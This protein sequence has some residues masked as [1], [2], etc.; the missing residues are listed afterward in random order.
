M[1]VSFFYLTTHPSLD[2][3]FPKLTIPHFDSLINHC[4]FLVQVVAL[5]KLVA[6]Q[7]LFPSLEPKRKPVYIAPYNCSLSILQIT[8]FLSF[9]RNKL[10]GLFQD[11]DWFFPDSKICFTIIAFTPKISM[12]NLLTVCHTVH[13][14]FY[15]RLTDFQNPPGSVALFQDFPDFPGP[16]QTLEL[17]SWWRDKF[18]CQCVK[19]AHKLPLIWWLFCLVKWRVLCGCWTQWLC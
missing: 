16:V 11:S 14:L 18:S 13:F 4:H 9:L 3:H 10:R 7:M 15:F 5:E 17:I 19:K 1:F 12:L 6:V 2:R 8:G